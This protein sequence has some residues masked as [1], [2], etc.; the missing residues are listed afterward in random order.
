MTVEV[1]TDTAATAA[2]EGIKTSKKSSFRNGKLAAALLAGKTRRLQRKVQNPDEDSAKN[3]ENPQNDRGKSV[4]NPHAA[5]NNDD[6][7]ATAQPTT[8]TTTTHQSMILLL[9][10]DKDKVSRLPASM[11]QRLTRRC[12]GNQPTV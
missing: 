7:I 10:S 3:L 12:Q 5:S 11:Q 8:T 1:P 6:D 4:G 2:V 9:S